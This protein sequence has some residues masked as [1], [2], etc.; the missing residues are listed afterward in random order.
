MT[1]HSLATA[2]TQYAA[3]KRL[4]AT[5][6]TILET[7]LI[8]LWAMLGRE[9]TC[10]D[11]TADT[12]GKFR[13]FYDSR[14]HSRQNIAWSAGAIKNLWAWCAKHSL[15]M[16]PPEE[17]LLT[18]KSDPTPEQIRAMCEDLRRRR[19]QIGAGKVGAA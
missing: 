8:E 4:A 19:T 11:L 16:P 10:G 15:S 6:I 18:R 17:F 5:S 1:T 2:I 3:D 12:V 14:R 7:H 9:P 13:E